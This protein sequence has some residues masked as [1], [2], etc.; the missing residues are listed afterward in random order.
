MPPN[1][2]ISRQCAITISVGT[3]IAVDER[4]DIGCQSVE[5]GADDP[6][7]IAVAVVA[8]LIRVRRLG[9]AAD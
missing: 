9:E 6:A 5:I 4:I 1:H 8:E 7:E 3:R 2:G